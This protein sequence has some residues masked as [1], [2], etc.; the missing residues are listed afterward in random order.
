MKEEVKTAFDN[1][2]IAVEQFKGTKQEHIAL[3]Q[4]LVLIQKEL[5]KICNCKTE[6]IK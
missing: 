2:R 3:E 1:I 6:E 5:S 4:C